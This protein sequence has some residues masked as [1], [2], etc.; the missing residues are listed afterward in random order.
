MVAV[1]AML[2]QTGTRAQFD[3]VAC[4]LYVYSRIDLNENEHNKVGSSDSFT[5]AML[6]M[7]PTF[8]S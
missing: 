8:I 5:H 4:Y 6:S 1:E 2:T 3:Q 7:P